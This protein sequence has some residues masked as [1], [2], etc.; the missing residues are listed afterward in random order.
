MMEHGDNKK[1]RRKQL[2]RLREK[3]KALYDDDVSDEYRASQ[4]AAL[5]LDSDDGKKALLA[6]KFMQQH[7]HLNYTYHTPR[8]THNYNS[9]PQSPSDWFF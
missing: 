3:V 6:T 2:V 8:T 1:A 5:L 7:T 4:L 9:F